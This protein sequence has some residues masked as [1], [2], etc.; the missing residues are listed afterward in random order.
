MTWT[1]A[2]LNGVTYRVNGKVVCYWSADLGVWVRS[3][4]LVMFAALR[5][6]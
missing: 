3:F 4:S 2:T 6:K 1:T 5:L